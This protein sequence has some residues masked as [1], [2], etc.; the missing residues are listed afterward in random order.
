MQ[1]YPPLTEKEM[2]ILDLQDATGASAPTPTR[3]QIKDV[4]DRHLRIA[5]IDDRGNV[6]IS[7]RTNAID[8]LFTL[9]TKGDTP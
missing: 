5:T 4:L 9:F 6:K 3:E 7:G 2:L 8:E 1:D